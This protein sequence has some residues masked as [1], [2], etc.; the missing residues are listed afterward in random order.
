MEPNLITELAAKGPMLTADFGESILNEGQLARFIEATEESTAILPMVRSVTMERETE[1]L[2]RIAFTEDVLRSAA[3]EQADG[4]SD[5]DYSKA[6]TDT[7]KLIAQERRGDISFRDATLR[8]IIGRENAEQQIVGLFG[9]A[10]GRSLERDAIF[11]HTDFAGE[12]DGQGKTLEKF[13]EHDGWIA[14]A[15]NKLFNDSFDQTSPTDV[16]D[17]MLGA[18]PSKFLSNPADWDFWMT[19]GFYRKYRAELRARETGL[20][21][22]SYTSDDQLFFEAFR[23]RH[24]DALASG[25]ADTLGVGEVVMLLHRDNTIHGLFHEVAIEPERVPRKRGTDYHLTLEGAAGFEEPDGACVAFLDKASEAEV[26]PD[27][28]E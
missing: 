14:R 10:A 6:S 24:A 15:G 25:I 18:V 19:F 17:K 26:G 13:G 4:P 1:H 5:N 23:C 27:F 8:R 28:T 7:V 9:N 16:M 22:S 20:G 11:S 12:L 2:D 21:D 3:G